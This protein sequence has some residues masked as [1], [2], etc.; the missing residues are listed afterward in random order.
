MCVYIRGLGQETNKYYTR[1]AVQDR[2]TVNFKTTEIFFPPT[3]IW[4]MTQNNKKKK[5]KV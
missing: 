2:I 5:K 1:Y 4:L 3:Q